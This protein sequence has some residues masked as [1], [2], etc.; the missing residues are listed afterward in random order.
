M[1]KR[2]QL[3]NDLLRSVADTFKDQ[4]PMKLLKMIMAQG[5]MKFHIVFEKTPLILTVNFR[6]G[7]MYGKLQLD[8][9]VKTG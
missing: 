4:D 6:D 3:D 1:D 5:P 7:A 9:H 2:E 8:D